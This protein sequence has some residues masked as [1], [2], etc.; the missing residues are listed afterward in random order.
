M[1]ER[2]NCRTRLEQIEVQT[3][4]ISADAYFAAA[5]CTRRRNG[6]FCRGWKPA[7]D[8]RRPHLCEVEA[9]LIVLAPHSCPLVAAG[10]ADISA[11]RL[12]TRL[13]VSDDFDS[14]RLLAIWHIG[15]LLAATDATPS[16]RHGGDESS[17][18]SKRYMFTRPPPDLQPHLQACGQ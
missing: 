9:R 18:A 11:G 1:R 15:P 13:R 3:S 2:L 12:P 5:P 17:A 8:I 6:Y 14:E 10:S 7:P 16:H 4:A